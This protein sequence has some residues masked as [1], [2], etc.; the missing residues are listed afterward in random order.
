MSPARA[1]DGI[2]AWRPGAP[3][4]PAEG[5]ARAVFDE[6]RAGPDVAAFATGRGDSLAAGLDA[7]RVRWI[8]TDGLVAPPPAPIDG[9]TVFTEPDLDA[10]RLTDLSLELLLGAPVPGDAA[11]VRVAVTGVHDLPWQTADASRVLDLTTSGLTPDSF[12]VDAPDAGEWFVALAARHDASLGATDPSGVLGQAAR[13]ERVLTQLATGRPVVLVALGGAGHAAR[14]A[15]DTVAGVT[16]L[17]TLGTPWSPV[18][19][20]TARTGAPADALRLLR[21][22]LPAPDPSEP[23]D[24]DLAVGRALVD[25]FMQAARGATP[26]TELEAPRPTTVVRAGLDVVA[27]FGA[28]TDATVDRALT[29]V[30]AAGLATRAQGRVV[31]ASTPPTNAT[32]GLRVP[33]ALGTHGTT[34]TGAL[35]VHLAT[36]TFDPA[37]AF[38]AAPADRAVARRRRHRRVVDRRTG[39]DT[40]GRRAS[41]GAAAPERAR[42]DRS[43]RRRVAVGARVARGVRARRHLGSARGPPA[44]RS[45][46]RPRDASDA[47]GSASTHRRAGDACL[48]ATAPGSPAALLSAVLHASAL[49]QPDGALVPDGLAHVLHD[50]GAH[51]RAL[52]AVEGSRDALLGALAG[53]APGVTATGAHVHGVVG[54]LTIDADVASGTLSA[55]AAGAEGIV[56]WRLATAFGPGAAPTFELDLGDVAGGFAVALRANPWTAELRRPHSSPVALFPAPD[57]DGLGRVAMSAVPAEALRILLEGLRAI[58]TAVGTTLDDLLAAIGMLAAPDGAGRRAI[59]APIALFDDP[60]AW[61]A[62]GGMLSTI[63]GGPLELDKVIDLLESLKPF[64][65]L[66]GTPRGT[67]PIVAGVEITAA[68]S[69]AGPT[70]SLA[71]DPTVWLAGDNTRPAFAAGLRA[72]I[73]LRGER[74]AH[75]DARGVRRRPRGH[76]DAP[77]PSRGARRPRRVEPA[78]L[79]APSDRRRPGAVPAP[80]RIRLAA[81]DGCSTVAAPRPRPA[82]AHDRR[83]GA[84]RDRST[85]QRCG[86]RARPRDG[87]TGDVRRQRV[88][89]LGR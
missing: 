49:C 41:H 1:G 33:I 26:I 12:A 35:D 16:H 17:V 20:D 75:P 64:I 39:H 32:I 24:D 9:V 53:L 85:C 40:G 84:R 38:E 78:R 57:L 46:R 88:A 21:A 73:A 2:R 63:D 83:R 86:A 29:A 62:R 77:A 31:I 45:D 69:A 76:A 7:L 18:A 48:V 3:G 54:P 72:G 89:D 58:D 81:D 5:L 56:G 59:V 34:V 6:A 27:V 87:R 60:A 51:F 79:P 42:G 36:L 19:F 80:R 74:R 30:I 82:R 43:A 67:W 66:A 37:I 25:G 61:F 15:A 10:T 65:G 52:L 71:V 22:L 50:P 28:L 14:L 44:D 55:T 8:G 23:D 68:A 4:L 13:L 70:I 47:S 11:V